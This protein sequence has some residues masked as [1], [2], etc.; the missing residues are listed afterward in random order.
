[1]A[2]LLSNVINYA[3]VLVSALRFTI[4]TYFRISLY[5]GEIF[6]DRKKVFFD[7]RLHNF[8][9]WMQLLNIAQWTEPGK[10]SN[11]LWKLSH[12]IYVHYQNKFPRGRYITLIPFIVDHCALSLC[13]CDLCSVSTY[14]ISPSI[15]RDLY[16]LLKVFA[17]AYIRERLI[18]GS[19]LYLSLIHIWRCR[20]LLTCRSRWSPYH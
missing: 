5:I 19:D 20:R 1:M 13:T 6:S 17:A 7:L 8:C 4:H 12:F 14:R 16:S 10:K 2:N 11:I 15:S 3:R 18:F 9:N